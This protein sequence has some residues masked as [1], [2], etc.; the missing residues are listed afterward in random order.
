MNVTE[1]QAVDV[2]VSKEAIWTEGK[3]IHMHP[4][5][6]FCVV[7]LRSGGTLKDQLVR[8]PVPSSLA[9]PHHLAPAGTFCRFDWRQVLRTSRGCGFYVEVWC[10]GENGFDVAKVLAYDLHLDRVLLTARHTSGAEEFRWISVDS[11][12]LRF[13]WDWE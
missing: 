10:R 5:L 9:D 3:V 2:Y 4:S 6:D 1:G 8:V 12:R 11:P 13:G 7:K